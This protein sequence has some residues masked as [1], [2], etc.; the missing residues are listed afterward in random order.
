MTVLARVVR[1]GFD[2]CEHHGSLVAIDGDG[3]ILFSVGEPTRPMFPRSSNK[4]IQAVGMVRAGLDLA[5]DL[6]AMAGASHSGEDVHVQQVQRILAGAGLDADALQCPPAYPMDE[7]SHAQMILAH[8]EPDRVHMNC[9]GKHSAML[10]TCVAAGWPIENYLDPEHP[11]QQVLAATVA[12]LAG[13]PIAAIGVDGC[14]APIFGISVL[15]LARAFSA[16]ASGAEGSAENRVAEAFRAN[17]ILTSGSTRDERFLV[18]GVPGILAKAGAEGCYGVAL[19]DGRAV[20]LKVEDGA[21]RAR[22]V[23]MAEALRRLGVDA[24]V[25]MTQLRTPVLGGGRVVGE[26]VAAGW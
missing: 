26:V 11:L 12:E 10:A 14:G 20:A 3:E 1:S 25:V 7:A 19:P 17:P 16:I 22:P 13:E 5:P 18:D 8:Q 6:L 4:P 15:G 23:V 9:S 21:E 24:P 2:E